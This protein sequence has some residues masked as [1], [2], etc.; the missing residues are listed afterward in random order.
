MLAIEGGSQYTSRL[1]DRVEI[2][3]RRKVGAPLGP[4][5]DKSFDGK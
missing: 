1:V 4:E 2:F 5:N 3:E